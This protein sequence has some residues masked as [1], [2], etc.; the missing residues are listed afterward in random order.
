M[1]AGRRAAAEHCSRQDH[2]LLRPAPVVECERVSPGVPLNRD[3]FRVIQLAQQML[4]VV[5]GDDELRGPCALR[6][7]NARHLAHRGRAAHVE[8]VIVGHTEVAL[9]RGPQRD[10]GLARPARVSLLVSHQRIELPH[11]TLAFTSGNADPISRGRQAARRCVRSDDAGPGDDHHSRGRA[12]RGRRSADCERHNRG[13]PGQHHKKYQPGSHQC[14][15]RPR[16]AVNGRYGCASAKVSAYRS[17]SRNSLWFV[18][19]SV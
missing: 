15:G 18:S 7:R 10:L 5:E 6:G 14:F 17:S 2:I 19:V 1:I 12:R 11:T 4:G 13:Q 8:W 16:P 9:K 3:Q